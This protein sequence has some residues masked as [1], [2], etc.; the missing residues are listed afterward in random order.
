[1]YEL[2]EHELFMWEQAVGRGL[3]RGGASE[4]EEYVI[5]ARKMGW[6]VG[7]CKPGHPSFE[8]FWEDLMKEK[9]DIQFELGEEE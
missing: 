9:A 3:T 4:R 2:A 5:Y 8:Y 7:A 1:M 6:D